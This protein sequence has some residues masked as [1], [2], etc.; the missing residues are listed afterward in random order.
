MITV[1]YFEGFKKAMHQAILFAASI[2]AC[3]FDLAKNVVDKDLVD[4]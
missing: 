2:Y 3:R 1:H 4:D